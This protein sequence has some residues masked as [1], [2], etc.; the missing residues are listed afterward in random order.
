MKIDIPSKSLARVLIEFGTW[1]VAA[2]A[3]LPIL[4]HR[5]AAQAV[6]SA[7]AGASESARAPAATTERNRA[8]QP[9]L[10]VRPPSGQLARPSVQL[11]LIEETPEDQ[12]DAGET[13]AEATPISLDMPSV[14][15]VWDQEIGKLNKPLYPSSK[16]LVRSSM[17]LVE[18]GDRRLLAIRSGTNSLGKPSAYGV[19]LRTGRR[20][21]F[22]RLDDWTDDQGNLRIAID[23]VSRNSALDRAGQ[24]KLWFLD[25]QEA[26]WSD[27][28]AWPGKDAAAS[29]TGAGPSTSP[30]EAG[31]E[32]APPVPQQ[33]L[34]PR[35]EVEPSDPVDDTASQTPTTEPDQ[36]PTEDST[37]PSPSPPDTVAAPEGPVEQPS[38]EPPASPGQPNRQPPEFPRPSHQREPPAPGDTKPKET[39]DDP[40]P[41]SRPPAMP[42]ERTAPS[43]PAPE[44]R[45]WTDG[46]GKHRIVAT[47]AERRDNHVILRLDEGD[48]VAVPFAALSSE[49]QQYVRRHLPAASSG[50]TRPPGSG[51]P[52]KSSE[53]SSTR[54]F[55]KP[56]DAPRNHPSSRWQSTAPA[57]EPG[58]PGSRPADQGDTETPSRAAPDGARG[59]HGTPTAQASSPETM[60]IDQLAGHIERRWGSTMPPGVRKNWVA[61]WHNYYRTENPLEVRR[62]V[63]M[64][65]L[66]SCYREQQPGELRDA[67][68][69][70]YVKLRR[71][72]DGRP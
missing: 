6:P 5:A 42:S 53:A 12:P 63:F 52:G 11:L 43:Q 24:L 3:S 22:C 25:G 35:A 36:P 61:G 39:H 41:T 51:Q 13:K 67:I 69:A 9:V 31:G 68:A 60:S 58:K 15:R 50:N 23:D 65:L 4:A 54:T 71:Q 34:P 1:L 62:A 47:L 72:K 28:I 33:M 32:R 48:L 44:P 2:A 7:A 29:Q 38:R 20:L 66:R 59:S 16:Q 56:E 17:Q 55:D 64:T 19:D 40:S 37:G 57:D 70:L 26:V 18:Y 14:L 27:S 30:A 10:V 46:S 21:V 8:G 49:D 45:I